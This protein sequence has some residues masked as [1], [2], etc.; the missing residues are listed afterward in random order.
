MS[1]IAGIFVGFGLFLLFVL[2]TA[3]AFIV[4]KL[5]KR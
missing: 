4:S 3:I 1:F 5:V 2:G